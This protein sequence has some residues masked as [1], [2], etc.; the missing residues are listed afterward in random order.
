MQEVGTRKLYPH[1]ILVSI[2]DHTLRDGDIDSDRSSA[3]FTDA[4]EF[5]RHPR[6]KSKPDEVFHNQGYDIAIIE[7]RKTVPLTTY[8]PACLPNLDESTR[9]EGK[10]ATSAGWGLTEHFPF[11]SSP[12][13]ISP[14]KIPNEPR[15]VKMRVAKSSSVRQLTISS[16][17]SSGQELLANPSK[18]IAGQ[19]HDSA[20]ICNVSLKHKLFVIFTLFIHSFV[21]INP[22]HK[23]A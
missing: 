7:L 4:D 22:K 1:E 13:T 23:R 10:I 21:S 19:F 20:S 12:V 8:P 5:A 17:G 18:L 15:E 11:P 14:N 16:Y 3:F 6:W 2:G 9:F